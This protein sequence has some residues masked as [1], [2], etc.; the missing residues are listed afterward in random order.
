MKNRT[1]NRPPNGKTFC[2]HVWLPH[3]KVG[4]DWDITFS[5]R[6]PV[7]CWKCGK[8]AEKPNSWFAVWPDELIDKHIQYR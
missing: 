8:I 4:P 7:I 2:Y 1:Y 5:V 3:G 6:V